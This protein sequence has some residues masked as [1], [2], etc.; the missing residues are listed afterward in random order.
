MQILKINPDSVRA[1]DLLGR[2]YLRTGKYQEALSQFA[3]VKGLKADDTQV[4]VKI[5]LVYYE[6]QRY[7]EAAEEF[8]QIVKDEPD[9]HRARYYLGISLQEA[10][11]EKQ[12]EEAFRLIPEEN[13]FYVDAVLHIA[14]IYSSQ[15]KDEKAREL[16]E[17]NLKKFP[18][19]PDFLVAMASL[20]EQGQEIQ[21]SRVLLARGFGTGTGQRR[22][23]FQAGGGAGSPGP[24]AGRHQADAAG[25]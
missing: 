12:A 3:I 2:L 19:E 6:L 7:E 4:Q 18:E 1:H 11:Q 20:L 17:Q 5:G 21:R 25:L 13:E 14:E 22:D 23:S 9:N 8:A 24:E 10:G 15:E 16:L